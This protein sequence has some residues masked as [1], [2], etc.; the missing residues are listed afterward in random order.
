MTFFVTGDLEVHLTGR[1]LPP[2]MYED[3]DDED[4]LYDQTLADIDDSGDEGMHL[5]V[6]M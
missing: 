3:E 4:M 6:A 1:L 5:V 2:E